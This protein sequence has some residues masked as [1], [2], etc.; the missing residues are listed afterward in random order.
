MRPGWSRNQWSVSAMPQRIRST[1]WSPGCSPARRSPDPTHR[2]PSP[3]L[4][5]MPITSP[6]HAAS[7]KNNE[8][9]CALGFSLHRQSNASG[10]SRKAKRL[11]WSATTCLKF[12]TSTPS[13]SS[14]VTARASSAAVMRIGPIG[15]AITPC[16]VSKSVSNLWLQCL[17]SCWR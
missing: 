15:N 4:S 14:M 12:S 8:I 9:C 7:R 10:A 5:P 11:R 1:R 6:V 16:W 13:C 17:Q 3:L 2:T